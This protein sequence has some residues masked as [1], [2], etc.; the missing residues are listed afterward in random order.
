MRLSD[1]GLQFR[2]MAYVFMGMTVLVSL[3]AFV[4]LQAVR[5]SS[6]EILQERLILARTVASAVDRAVTTTATLVAGVAETIG[7][8]GTD[9][10]AE[11][12][13]SVKTLA[14]ALTDVNAG[15]PPELVAL[16][17]GGG[18]PIARVGAAQDSAALLAFVT[19]LRPDGAP[20]IVGGGAG[21]P[22][23]ATASSLAG[24]AGGMRLAAVILPSPQLL[25]VSDAASGDVSSYHTELI[26][27]AGTVLETSDGDRPLIP[28]RH[29]EIIGD[30]LSLRISGVGEHSPPDADVGESERHVVAFAPLEAM[31]WSIVVEQPEDLA[32]AVP[33]DLRRRILWL[34][35]LGFLAGLGLAWITSRQVVRPLTRLT[36]RARRIASGDLGGTIPP[37][38]QD[39]IRRLSVSFETMRSRMETS[40]RELE[41]WGQEL[42]DR[43]KERTAEL[44]RRSSERDLLLQKVMNAQEEERRRIARDLHD[45]VGQS[46]TALTMSLGSA[47]AELADSDRAASERIGELRQVAGDTIEEVRRMMADLRPSILDDMGLSAAVGWYLENHL[48]RTGVESSLEV[49]DLNQNLPD[50]VE[51]TAFRVVQ[52]ALNN[53]VKHARAGHITV[54]L[55][56]G[57]N[58]ITGEVIDDGAG[59]NLSD[60][61]PG[62]D[63]GWAVGLLGMNER[64]T[65]LG[66][67]LKIDTAP[68]AGTSVRFVI[69]L[70]QEVVGG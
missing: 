22:L 16:I 4:A 28:T 8:S 34:A 32:L 64:V 30:A 54:R 29:L 48:E 70:S 38:G 15:T 11:A 25:R 7:R 67:S 6:D 33:N 31:P 49:A 62:A 51:I 13:I 41:E 27:A 57:D 2:I 56:G 12:E 3:F 20:V 46:L 50:V 68:G 61:E 35:S 14:L 18:R 40:Q 26:D 44:A 17:D 47:E 60:V 19:T 43:V 21:G 36:E 59:F 63:G 65:L 9:I 42:E 10:L 58:R 1:I 37:E 24:Q 52:E 45:Q 5:D 39:E 55:T 23:I 69:P 66:G 53:V